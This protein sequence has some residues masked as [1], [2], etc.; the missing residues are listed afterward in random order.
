MGLCKCPK[1]KVTNLFCFE[2]KVNVCEYCIV[3]E[4]SRCVVQSYLQWLQDSDFKAEC[5][6]CSK[7]LAQGDVIRLVCYDV[8][9]LSCL[10][11][12]ASSLPV[13]TAP[14]GYTCPKCKSGI[15]PG[16][17][18]VSPVVDEIRRLLA[19]FRWAQAGLGRP[20]VSDVNS[21][22]DMSHTPSGLDETDYHS[23]TTATTTMSAPSSSLDE[24]AAQLDQAIERATST[25][26][27]A[28]TT[29]SGVTRKK[30][31]VA[32][33]AGYSESQ[34]V[35]RKVV[36][37]RPSG[38]THVPMGVDHDEDKYRR[39]GA[40]DFLVRWTGLK[41]GGKVGKER[42]AGLHRP[43]IFMLLVLL[44]I[45]SL[46]ILATRVTHTPTHE[47]GSQFDPL[48]NP[49]VHVQQN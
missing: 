25:S 41:F 42:G 34:H 19:P 16:E 18:Y 7:S 29:T 46:I 3:G 40:L 8:F 24:A 9:H 39:R 17:N 21:E 33:S 1:R 28:T 23:T 48:N 30:P 11:R 2:H 20:V 26:G 47:A 12:H 31:E 10:D 49:N 4:H 43:V 15:F 38:E 14:A 44:G 6:L 22:R 32:A 5:G 13:N 45:M 37:T 35:Q 36:D 27:R